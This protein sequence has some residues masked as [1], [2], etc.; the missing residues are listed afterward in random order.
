M[1]KSGATLT[2]TNQVIAELAGNWSTPEGTA[3]V[4][5]VVMPALQG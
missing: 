3:I 4:Q 1:E 5:E 2:S